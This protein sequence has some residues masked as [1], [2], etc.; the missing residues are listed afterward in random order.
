MSSASATVA[1]PMARLSS[2][3]AACSGR[4]TETLSN[5]CAIAKGFAA[6]ISKSPSEGLA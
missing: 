2:I 3:P 1:V 6:S 5:R 4:L